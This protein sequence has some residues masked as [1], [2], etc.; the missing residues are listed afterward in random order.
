VATALI[1]G[2]SSGIGTEF[3][4]ALARRNTD[5]I[6][7]ARRQ[8]RL[9][10]LAEQLSQE[11]NVQARAIPQDLLAPD[12]G[13][14][15]DAAIAAEGLSVDLLINNAGFGDYGEFGQSD[16]S[17]QLQMLDLNV[18]SLV[19][20]TYRFLAPMQQRGTGSIINVASIAAFQPLP[21]MSTYAASKSFVLSFT[22]ALWAENRA[23]GIKVLALCPGPTE[24]E[25]F[26]VAG[27]DKVEPSNKPG[28]N[29]LSAAEV[30][31]RALE[32]LDRGDANIV[33]G[34]FATQATVNVSRFL[35]R[36]F[37]VE[38]VEK[39]FRPKQS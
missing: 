22:E 18:R 29:M 32:A 21:Y 14:T 35:P 38:G 10:A 12:A 4:R 16:L 1:T 39:F 34:D 19:E 28:G 33:T 8:D 36:Q 3:A 37:L 23:K 6:L 9:E 5:L 24:T 13:E 11:C 31:D 2:A 20:L 25:F 7:V 27:F 26:K 15:L 17:K 30:V